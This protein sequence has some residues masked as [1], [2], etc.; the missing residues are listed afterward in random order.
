MLAGCV[1]AER[2]QAP[3]SNVPRAQV[4]QAADMVRRA[5]PG[6]QSGSGGGESMAPIYG[7]NTTLV[8]TPIEFDK[9]EADMVVAYRGKDGRRIV[10]RL[11]YRQG[12]RW[13]ARGDNNSE[14]DPEPV[15]RDNLLGVVYAVFTSAPAVI[16]PAAQ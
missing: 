2:G 10:H 5:E 15:T 3:S 14:L 16:P 6:R 9:L 11:A 8:I 12:D 4:Y 13:F 7:E 1:G